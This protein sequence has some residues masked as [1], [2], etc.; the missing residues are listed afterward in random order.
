MWG[1]DD[2]DFRDRLEDSPRCI[3]Q[4]DQAAFNASKLETTEWPPGGY[5]CTFAV[6]LPEY[7]N[8]KC[9]TVLRVTVS[10]A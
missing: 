10:V 9:D 4:D 1:S 8:C 6:L 2:V 7:F 5:W 3:K